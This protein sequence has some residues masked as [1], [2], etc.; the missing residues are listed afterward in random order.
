MRATFT[1]GVTLQKAEMDCNVSD[2]NWQQYIDILPAPSPYYPSQAPAVQAVAPPKFFDPVP[3][4]WVTTPH[5]ITCNGKTVTIGALNGEDSNPFYWGPSELMTAESS[6]D[7]LT[8]LDRP[9]DV[10]LSGLDWTGPL[11]SGAYMEFTTTLAGVDANDD[12][13]ALPVTDTWDWITTFNRT[14]G[15]AAAALKNVVP[16]DPGSGTAI[17]QHRWCPGARA[18]VS[19]A[20]SLRAPPVP[21][22]VDA[23]DDGLTA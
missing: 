22:L 15:M 5:K 3:G 10:C 20:P 14:A 1:P 21:D 19:I 23:K 6:G 8:F 4:G 2:F 17:D 18:V 16:I 13:V 11:T 7:T 9:T 12:P